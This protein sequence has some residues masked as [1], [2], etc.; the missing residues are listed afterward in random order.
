MFRSFMVR[1]F[2]LLSHAKADR[3][4]ELHAAHILLGELAEV[5]GQALFINGAKLFQQYDGLAFQ[6]IIVDEDMRRLLGFFRDRSDGRYN[7]GGTE[8]VA[9]IVLQDEDRACAALFA[10]HNGRKVGVLDFASFN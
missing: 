1:R 4:C 7:G 6:K 8:M 9:G 5:V 3:H 2:F 10:A